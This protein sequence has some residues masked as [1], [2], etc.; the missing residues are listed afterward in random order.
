M[1]WDG[2]FNQTKNKA[3]S[4]FLQ[5]AVTLLDHSAD[6]AALDLGS[7][8]GRDARLLIDKGFVVT[9]VDAAP[10]AVEYAPQDATFLQ[11]SFENFQFNHYD[12]INASYSLPFIDAPD[13][14]EVWQRIINAL[15]PNGFFVGELFGAR[16]AWN[17]I[18]SRMNFH[19]RTEVE[20][21]LANLKI[22]TLDEEEGFRPT[23]SGER[24]FWHVFHIIAQRPA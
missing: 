4:P 15:N 21:L 23:A 6:R 7:G 11:A 9:C 1:S 17:N 16:D 5:K 22:H 18:D 2:Y 3:P 20:N 10:I 13:F 12:L 14:P 8:G 19:T 24:K